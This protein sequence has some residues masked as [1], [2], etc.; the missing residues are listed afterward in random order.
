M[1]AQDFNIFKDSTFDY[2][3]IR[4]IE[5]ENTTYIDYFRKFEVI[6]KYSNKKSDQVDIPP[7]LSLRMQRMKINLESLRRN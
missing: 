6:L 5:L 4:P 1:D 7:S 2:Y 3:M